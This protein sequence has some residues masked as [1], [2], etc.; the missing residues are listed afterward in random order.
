MN[1]NLI[2]RIIMI[3][4]WGLPVTT[5][6][7]AIAEEMETGVSPQQQSVREQKA[8]SQLFDVTMESSYTAAGE[9]KFRGTTFDDSDAYN[10]S[11][12]LNSRITLNQ[13]W[14]VPFELKSRNLEL[15]ALTGVPIPDG[16]HTLQFGTGL[17]YTPSDRWMFMARI[18]PTLYKFS[19]VS[20]ND[21]GFSGSLTATWKY[22]PSLKFMFGVIASPDSDIK[23]L[24]IAGL[25]W[26]ISDQLD[27]RLMLPK[28]QLIYTPN[29]RW[30]FHVGAEL[31]T[32]IFR[33]SDS[34]GT[35]IGLPQ[36]NDEIGNYRDIRIGTGICYRFS[37]S[38]SMEADVGYSVNRQIDY[39][40][41]DETVEFASAPYAGLGLRVNF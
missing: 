27:L 12:D 16:I 29:D 17:G 23:V 24:P 37:K 2:A 11:L 25:D 41:I 1:Q 36:Y 38:I 20:G 8:R 35:S 32:A 7:V 39:T 21:M 15:G 22:N 19:D 3:I 28:P 9:T 10:I 13:H 31:N 6:A 40:E 4:A 30:R 34:L 26:I 33:T 5:P 18:A 14:M